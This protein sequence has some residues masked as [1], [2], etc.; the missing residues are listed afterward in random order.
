MMIK[1]ISLIDISSNNISSLPNKSFDTL[2][3]LEELILSNNQIEQIDS[4]AFYGLS[5]LKKLVLQ[6]CALTRIPSDAL[7][8]IRTLA[9]LHLTA[10]SCRR[11][12]RNLSWV[13]LSE[14]FE[15]GRQSAAT[16]PD[17]GVDR[18]EI[19]RSFKFRKIFIF[20]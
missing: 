20:Y 8:R 3:N 17:G 15:T 12:E 6:N 9:A 2:P 11:G 13:Q 4:E 1:H 7:R 10:I 16:D 14:E 19:T 5:S 18:I